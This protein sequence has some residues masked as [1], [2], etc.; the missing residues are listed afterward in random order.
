MEKR[1]MKENMTKYWTH[2][3]YEKKTGKKI[4]QGKN[5]LFVDINIKVID[6]YILKWNICANK[7]STCH[8]IFL[9]QIWLEM[10]G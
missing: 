4:N 2:Y 8:G 1:K 5:L 6:I 10:I 3:L 9:K 7:L